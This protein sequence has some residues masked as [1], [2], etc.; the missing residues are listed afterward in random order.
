MI[1]THSHIYLKDFQ[2]D[3]TEML[4][5]AR[6]AGVRE[7]YLPNIDSDSINALNTTAA[8][9]EMC[10]PMMGLHP[11]SV[12][13]DYQEQLSE[14]FRELEDPAKKFYA[15]GEIGLDLYWD[16]TYIE[17]QMKAFAIQIEKAKEMGLPIVIHCREAFDEVFDILEAYK[18][19]R[20][21]GIF[22][23][24]TGTAEQAQRAIDLNMKLGIG[25]VVTF[26][27][28]GLDKVVR[29]ID[30]EHFVLE[31][32]APYLA[33]TPFRGKRNEPSY[34]KYVAQKVADLKEVS[35]DEVD[36][37][38]TANAKQVFEGN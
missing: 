28:A 33:P 9:H 25:G 3:F 26:K 8:N 24:F 21:F 29:D 1:D 17:Q 30:L 5:R 16:K 18:D 6:A 37:I 4:H 38:T 20:L 32:D 13:E 35:L 15:V 34:L 36:K 22:H 12:K 23:C 14:I 27:N 31:T 7:V 11:G 2:E 10:K 19:E